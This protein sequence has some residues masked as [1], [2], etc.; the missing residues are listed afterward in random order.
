[1]SL[2]LSTFYTEREREAARGMPMSSILAAILGSDC[3]LL[4]L[5]L[6][7]ATRRRLFCLSTVA[8]V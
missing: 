1:M 5:Q 2:A 8:V 4:L 3:G 7:V 6:A